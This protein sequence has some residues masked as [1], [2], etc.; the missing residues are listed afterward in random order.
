MTI[1]VCSKKSG[2]TKLFQDDKKSVWKKTANGAFR[3]IMIVCNFTKRILWFGCNTLVVG[4]LPFALMAFYHQQDTIQKVEQNQMM[5][6]M[7]FEE[8]TVNVRPF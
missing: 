7:Q 8:P 3:F 5:G 6:G 4:V 1:L 2:Y